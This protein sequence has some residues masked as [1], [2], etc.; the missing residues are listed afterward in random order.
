ECSSVTLNAVFAVERLAAGRLFLGVDPVPD[1]PL[2][3]ANVDRRG[4][5]QK[6]RRSQDSRAIHFVMASGGR[7]KAMYSPEYGPPLTATTMNCLPLSMYVIGE[8]LCG[9]GM[10]TAPTSLP[11]TLS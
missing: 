6:P 10:K 1:R 3:C 11:V 9:A 7:L 8:P 4:E 5:Q 2:L